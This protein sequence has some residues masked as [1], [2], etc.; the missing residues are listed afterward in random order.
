MNITITATPTDRPRAH[1]KGVP[2]KAS[3]N[4][5]HGEWAACRRVVALLG[6]GLALGA[7]APLASAQVYNW[8]PWTS[9][10]GGT[11]AASDPGMGTVT[12][13]SDNGT[14]VSVPFPIRFDGV[15]FT[16][17]DA[18]SAGMGNG[19]LQGWTLWID[20]AAVPNTS[21]V[22]VGIGNFGHGT[23]SLPGYRLA[24]FDTLGLAMPLTALEQI[25]SY[26]HTWTSSGISFNDDVT[27]NTGS[28]DFVV[29]VVAGLNDN[30]S[31]ILLMSLPAGVGRLEVSTVG[32]TAAETI[33]VVI[34]TALAQSNIDPAHKFAWGENIGW[35]NWH[36]AG[37]PAGT[38]G[39]RVE[40]TFLSGFIWAEN[41]GWINLGDGTPA[42][43]VAYANVNG[44]DFGVNRDPD[45][46]ELYG[47]GWGENVG[48]LN[49]DGG[50]QATPP[51]PARLDPAD[52]T[53]AG[54]VWGENIGWINLDD[55][56]AYV[57]L[58]PSVCAAGLLG[59]LNCD[60]E[61]GFGDINPFVLFLSNFAAWQAAYPGCP[62]TNGDINGDGTYPSFGDIN[63]FVAL[64]TGS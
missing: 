64:L 44:T 12:M 45:S 19:V 15:S 27:L 16:P 49:F 55:A 22:I 59:D 24:A 47:L 2:F 46:D 10:G 43:G 29:T 52:C 53:L 61:V 32:P 34:A 25:G 39:V 14:G 28:G 26:D 51:N 7:G 63:P 18:P 30:N 35:T 36:D 13:G 8:V 33:N 40:A 50:A 6:V 11:V 42:N 4:L 58:E 62:P 5:W 21:G 57:G 1:A 56:N 9:I 41:V 17:V 23:P 31:D 20:F 37:D 3:T 38:L 48:W 60:G 54:Y